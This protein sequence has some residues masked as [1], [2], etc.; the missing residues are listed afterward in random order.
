[1]ELLNQFSSLELYPSPV[2]STEPY[3]SK[4]RVKMRK[5]LFERFDGDYNLLLD[6]Y[7]KLYGDDYKI[8]CRFLIKDMAVLDKLPKKLKKL[9][10]KKIKQKVSAAL[11]L[12]SCSNLDT[13]SIK[14]IVSFI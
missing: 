5:K 4:W 10:E 13:Y 7:I 14:N 2:R 9:R 1:M 8:D 6:E 3:Y 11:S 12:F